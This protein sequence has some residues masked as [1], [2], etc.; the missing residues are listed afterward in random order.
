MSARRAHRVGVAVVAAVVAVAGVACGGDREPLRVGV[1]VECDSIFASTRP[2]ALAG[3]ALPLVERGAKPGAEPRRRRGRPGRRPARSRSSPRAPQVTRFSPPDRR[4][5]VARGVGGSRRRRRAA[6]DA[7]GRDDAPGRREVPGRDVPRRHGRRPGDDT[8]R[9]ATEPLPVHARRRPE[10]RRA[11]DLRLREARAGDGPWSSP[12]GIPDGWEVT[13]GFVA[14]FCSLGGSIVERDFQSLLFAPDPAAAATRHAGSADGVA[15]FATAASPVAVPARATRRPSARASARGSSSPGRRSSINRASPRRTSTLTGVV[16]G[17]YVPLD[18]D[19]RSMRAYR[20]VAEARLSDAPARRGVSRPDVCVV[21]RGRGARLGARGDGRR[22]RRGTDG[23]ARRTG[24]ARA[25]AP[26]GR[27]AT[28]W[29]PAGD[30]RDLARADRANG[31]RQG[32]ARGLCDRRGRRPALRRALHAGDAAAVSLHARVREGLSARLGALS[33]RN[34]PRVPRVGSPR[35]EATGADTAADEDRR[36]VRARRDRRSRRPEAVAM[37]AVGQAEAD[38]GGP[39]CGPHE[40][41]RL[42]RDEHRLGRDPERPLH[43]ERRVRQRAGW[44]RV[45]SSPTLAPASKSCASNARASQAPSSTAA[46]SCSPPTN[47][48][49]TS[50]GPASGADHDADVARGMAEECEQPAVLEQLV[51]RIDEHEVGVLLRCHSARGRP[52]ARAT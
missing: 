39:R 16:L 1:L 30:R 34:R 11:R 13:A 2:G 33:A 20:A 40:R 21:H 28:R 23:A 25:R 37:P 6:R 22:A 26:A 31:V 9:P 36:P 17:G 44:R 52:R 51:R 45:R 14:E 38:D 35:R 32:R 29:E 41:V 3:A 46:Q 18:P 50:P 7:R 42:G 19:D 10:R 8:S 49:R 27:G 5:P 47:G 12:R 24:G 43:R 4:D 48:T 15:L